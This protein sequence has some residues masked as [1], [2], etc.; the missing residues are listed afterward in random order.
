M[1]TTNL[2]IIVLI[3]GLVA[4]FFI[5]YY[6]RQCLISGDTDTGALPQSSLIKNW[7]TSIAGSVAG[8]TPQAITISLDGDTFTIPISDETKVEKTVINNGEVVDMIKNLSL[9]DVKQGDFVNVAIL[10][11]LDGSFRTNVIYLQ[12]ITE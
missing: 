11:E 1:K 3:I 8:I 4:G 6:S 12:E 2:I 7:L 5:G 9:K 10:A